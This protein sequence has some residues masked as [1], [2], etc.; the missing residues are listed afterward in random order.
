LPQSRER[1]RL[2]KS[3]A[4]DLPQ[5]RE[6]VPAS[7]KAASGCR[8]S[9]KSWFQTTADETRLD[10]EKPLLA[11]GTTRQFFLGKSEFIY[12]SSHVV[13]TT[14]SS[15]PWLQVDTPRVAHGI[16]AAS[17]DTRIYLA[18]L[19]ERWEQQYSARQP[20]SDAICRSIY[21]AF[22]K[23]QRMLRR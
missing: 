1:C 21:V 2:A 17:W 15:T 11:R 22:I 5:R 13:F 18:C 10:T 12:S 20:R 8:L 9:L 19:A 23:A 4:A 7:L 3:W 6:R 16:H 14:S